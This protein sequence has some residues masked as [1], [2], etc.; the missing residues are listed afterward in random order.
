MITYRTFNIA[1]PAIVAGVTLVAG[2]CADTAT[3]DDVSDARQTFRQE[4]QETAETVREGQQ[5]VAEARRDAQPYTVNMPVTSDDTA[6]AR[7]DVAEA[8]QEAAENVREQVQEQNEA[9]TE[10][11]TTEQQYAATQARDE[12]IA[13]TAVA[14]SEL[15][16]RAA[17]ARR[18]RVAA[19]PAA[20]DRHVGPGGQC[21]ASGRLEIIG[22]N[23]R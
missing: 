21:P 15:Q 22:E 8:Q 1:F 20:S 4:Q 12:A 17:G 6:E 16:R 5:E 3:R 7:Q 18:L 13:P 10:L 11:R 19:F 9:A 2:G 23:R 14:R